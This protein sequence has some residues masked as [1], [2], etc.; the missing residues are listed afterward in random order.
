MKQILSHQQIL[1]IVKRMAYEIY[2]ENYRTQALFLAGIDT[3]GHKISELIKT[4]IEEISD[5]R[6]Q[7][8]RIDIDKS[9]ISQPKVS[10]SAKP[11]KSNFTL[12]I[13]DDVL[14][15]GATMTY[16]LRPFLEMNAAK[17]QTAVLVNRSHKRF[18]IAVNYKGLE[19]GTTIEEHI[20]VQ[21][22]NNYVAF[23]H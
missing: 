2:E 13:I 12:I 6:I 21:L 1:Q 20:N 23:L 14:N 15:S 16:A 17:I 4:Q 5:I 11:Q 18:P 22:D 3:N 10:F 9:A 19:L 7:L 8:I